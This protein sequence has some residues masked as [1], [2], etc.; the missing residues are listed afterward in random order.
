M[1]VGGS[2]CGRKREQH[3]PWVHN[4]WSWVM[5]TWRFALLLFMFK[6]FQIKKFNWFLELDCN[7]PK[8]T[9]WWLTTYSIHNEAGLWNTN[10]HCVYVEKTHAP[11]QGSKNTSTSFEITPLVTTMPVPL[12]S[13]YYST[14]DNTSSWH[15][16]TGE[17]VNWTPVREGL[18]VRD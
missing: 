3:W 13:T 18:T 14:Q 7:F 6:I 8:E 9:L 17:S 16:E 11:A 2:G 12:P 5:N 10:H 1:G 4:C 15:G